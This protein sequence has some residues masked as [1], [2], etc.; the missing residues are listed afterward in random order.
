MAGCKWCFPK[1]GTRHYILDL[2]VFRQ[3]IPHFLYTKLIRAAGSGTLPLPSAPQSPAFPG[4]G[5][6]KAEAKT[7]MPIP[8]IVCPNLQKK[9]LNPEIISASYLPELTKAGR[10][11]WTWPAVRIP[12]GSTCWCRPGGFHCTQPTIPPSYASQIPAY[13]ELILYNMAIVQI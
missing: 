11:G 7:L 8:E 6:P 10:S 9:K 2:P 1:E 13:I 4:T 5:R 12:G 3:G